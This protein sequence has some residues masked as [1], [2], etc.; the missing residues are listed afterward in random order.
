MKEA[1]DREDRDGAGGALN[2][3]PPL[4]PKGFQ[5]PMIIGSK[6]KIE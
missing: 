2:M 3:S 4:F 6:S 5:M 1:P